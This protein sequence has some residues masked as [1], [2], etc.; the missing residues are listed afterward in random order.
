MHGRDRGSGE[1]FVGP[2][3]N[4]PDVRDDLKQSSYRAATACCHGTATT[5]KSN[6]RRVPSASTRPVARCASPSMRAHPRAAMDRHAVLAQPRAHAIVPHLAAAADAAAATRTARREARKPSTKTLRAAAS[7]ARSTVSLKALTTTTDQN[8]SIARSD[9]PCRRSHWPMVS[10]D[11]I[12]CLGVTPFASPID[13]MSRTIPQRSRARQVLQ[14]HQAGQQ[15]QRGGQPAAR[16]RNRCRAVGADEVQCRGAW[17]SS[18]RARCGGRSR[19]SW[20]S[21]PSPRAGSS[22]SICR[23]AGSRNEPA[24]PPSCGRLEQFDAKPALRPPPRRRPAR[25]PAADDR[26][27]CLHQQC[28]LAGRQE[29]PAEGDAAVSGAGSSRTRRRAPRRARGRSRRS[30]AR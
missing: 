12:R 28:R 1:V 18:R 27:G 8:R 5:T 14:P 26:H 20:C 11:A 3:S 29:R 24:R 4:R 19:A 9:C 25:Q 2:V 22:R 23:S 10:S 6:S 21:S 7:D 17:R 15:V 16:A 13:P 30:I